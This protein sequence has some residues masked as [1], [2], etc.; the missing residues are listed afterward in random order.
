MDRRVRLYNVCS[1]LTFWS[2]SLMSFQ[3]DGHTSPLLHTIHIPSLPLTSQ[4]SVTFHPSGNSILLTGNR[5]YYM[6]YDLQ[7][8][9]VTNSG[10]KA[11]WSD[12]FTPTSV[13]NTSKKRSRTNSK[14]T[15]SKFG[16][17]GADG[18]GGMHVHAFSPTGSLFAVAAPSSQI[19]LLDFAH[20][21]SQP[22]ATLKCSAPISSLWF[23]NSTTLAA[24]TEDAQVL[25]WDVGERKCVRKWN[26]VGGF[27][28]GGGVLAGSNRSGAN[29][30]E[31]WLAIG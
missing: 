8:G 17:G 5:P 11:L 13:L 4:S 7:K 2:F 30:D 28:G 15:G 21:S 1:T 26:D 25:L 16:K 6:I 29:G 10:A 9:T 24:L 22:I 20:P 19:H 27:R 31:G 12:N 23:S 18:A 3:V 14:K